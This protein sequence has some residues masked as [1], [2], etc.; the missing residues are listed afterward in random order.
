MKRS[1]KW[2]LKRFVLGGALSVAVVA[3][4]FF[5]VTDYTSE[6]SHEGTTG[7]TSEAAHPL[8]L[9]VSFPDGVTPTHPVPLTIEVEN[10][11]AVPVELAGPQI[12]IKTPTDPVCASWMEAF[13]EN[14]SGTE[15]TGVAE[16]ISGADM[17]PLKPIPAGAGPANVLSYYNGTLKQI[18]LRFKPSLVA[19]TDQTSCAN[20]PV[21]VTA[22]LVTPA[23]P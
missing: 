9:T 13:P 19:G 22:K 10:D 8:P 11:A 3:A 7:S 1:P 16:R 17:R 4:A 2:F 15:N 14:E 21:K 23:K 5:V 12:E 18:T 20:Q 6:G